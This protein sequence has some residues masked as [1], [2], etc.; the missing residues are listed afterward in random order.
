MSDGAFAA[1]EIALFAAAT[2]ACFAAS[3]F[4]HSRDWL[5]SVSCSGAMLL[6]WAVSNILWLLGAIEDWAIVADCVLLGLAATFW[7]AVRRPWIAAV[8]LLAG[9]VL[10]FDVSVHLWPIG[11]LWWSRISN[12]L[13]LGQLIAASYPGWVAIFRRT[14]AARPPAPAV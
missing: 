11:Y 5:P 3:L 4:A 7:I 12:I 13:Y 14:P 10:A 6:I 8:A 2:I 9:L 1:A